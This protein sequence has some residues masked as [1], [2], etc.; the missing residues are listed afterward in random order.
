MGKRQSLLFKSNRGILALILRDPD[1]LSIIHSDSPLEIT[2]NHAGELAVLGKL[3][4]RLITT[5][6]PP[7]PSTNKSTRRLKRGKTASKPS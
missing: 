3:V 2:C 7:K 4:R 1:T 5:L 6:S